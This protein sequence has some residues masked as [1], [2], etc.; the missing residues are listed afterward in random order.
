MANIGAT[1][2]DRKIS[3]RKL[4]RTSPVRALGGQKQVD[5]LVSHRGKPPG[6]ERGHSNLSSYLSRSTW[7]LP[8]L[9]E[10]PTNRT[11]G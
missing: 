6:F 3:S 10:V 9:L 2:K 5:G 8:V 1:H 4:T 11:A 7:A